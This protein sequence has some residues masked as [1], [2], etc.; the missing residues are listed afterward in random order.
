MSSRACGPVET[1][2]PAIVWRASQCGWVKIGK[3]QHGHDIWEKPDGERMV[4]RAGIEPLV[5][6]KRQIDRR[7]APE[8]P[9]ISVARR[10]RWHF[11]LVE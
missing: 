5:P 8:R 2:L 3:T 7:S 11:T 9:R 6:A 1:F 4:I 10:R